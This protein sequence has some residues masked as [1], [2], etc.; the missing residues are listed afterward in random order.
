M[1]ASILKQNPFLIPYGTKVKL[2]RDSD[3]FSFIG[4]FAGYRTY[5]REFLTG[6][7]DLSPVFKAETKTGTMS[8]RNAA[9]AL[10]DDDLKNWELEILSI[11]TNT[12]ETSP[13]TIDPDRY[14]EMTV[15]TVAFCTLQL[16]ALAENLGV[17]EIDFTQHPD[18]D[19]PHA[20]FDNGGT[21]E[22]YD[23]NKWLAVRKLVFNPEPDEENIRISVVSEED[24][25]EGYLDNQY[26]DFFDIAE[27]LP[28]IF[29]SAVKILKK[30]AESKS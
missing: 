23:S 19:T 29:N 25:Y 13:L 17:K 22:N 21:E 5:W 30:I 8:N 18:I 4:F 2:T 14:S 9:A 28:L 1:K 15:N 3:N 26:G 20:V 27:S 6:K 10:W 11:P 7:S 24:G 12:Y 16:C